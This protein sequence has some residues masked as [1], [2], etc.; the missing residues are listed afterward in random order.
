MIPSPSRQVAS[1]DGAASKDPVDV[2]FWG[3]SRSGVEALL[4]ASLTHFGPGQ[5]PDIGTTTV[6]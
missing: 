5:S 4:L 2:R 6:L 1:P 3:Q